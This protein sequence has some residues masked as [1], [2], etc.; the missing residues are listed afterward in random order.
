MAFKVFV[1]FSE[2]IPSKVERD[3]ARAKLK[4]AFPNADMVFLFGDI[5][6]NAGQGA[7]EKLLEL[8]DTIHRA[9]EKWNIAIEV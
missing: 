9:C 2:F 3:L 1:H 7:I 5:D 4:E 8:H 6:L